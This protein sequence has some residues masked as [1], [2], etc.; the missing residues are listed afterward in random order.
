MGTGFLKPGRLS[1]IWPHASTLN[2][3][4]G[5]HMSKTLADLY[6]GLNVALVW[7]NARAPM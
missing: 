5:Y 7:C 4:V 3:H 1:P 6:E 2:L